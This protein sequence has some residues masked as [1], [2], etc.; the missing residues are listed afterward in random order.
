MDM[1]LTYEK[2]SDF[3]YL[4]EILSTRNDWS[5]EINIRYVAFIR[6]TLTYGCKA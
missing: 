3:R 5:K 2:L 1:D 6:T 4:G